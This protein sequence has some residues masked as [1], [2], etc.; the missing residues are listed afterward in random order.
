MNRNLE[1]AHIST[2]E[3]K[4]LRKFDSLKG[5]R[6]ANKNSVSLRKKRVKKLVEI[7]PLNTLESKANTC[8][9][10]GVSF[11]GGLHNN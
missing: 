3:V 7:R 8:S 9:H 2:F 11:C 4:Y 5:F 6:V 10:F 1:Q